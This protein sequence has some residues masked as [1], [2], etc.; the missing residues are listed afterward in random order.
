MKEQRGFQAVRQ[1]INRETGQG[2]AGTVWA[3]QESMQA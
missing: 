1:M 3:D 2:A